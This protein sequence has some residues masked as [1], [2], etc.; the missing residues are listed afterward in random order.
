MTFVYKII[1][2]I[3]YSNGW[4]A[5]GALSMVWQVE[6]IKDGF[7]WNTDYG[8]FLFFATLFV[9]AIHRLVGFTNIEKTVQNR[10]FEVINQFRSHIVIY[11]LIAATGAIYYFLELPFAVVV[12]LLVPIAIAGLYILP[13][14]NG[15]RFR[16]LPYVKLFAIGIVWSWVTVSVSYFLMEGKFDQGL[17]ILSL[18]KMAF[19]IGITIPFDIRDIEVD[20]LYEIKT[21]PRV[22]GVQTSKYLA[23]TSILLSVL[24]AVAAYFANVYS[25]QQLTG[26]SAFYALTAIAIAYVTPDR[27]D[28]YFSGLL[29]GSILLQFVF[30]YFFTIG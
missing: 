30:M 21:L 15:R 25:V 12:L 27:H 16:D 5:L 10:R 24:L 3:L 2:L 6:L 23:L 11:A 19:I 26:M 4:I 7:Q 29:D 22:L 9:Y 28:Y 1:D 20:G 18:E 13:V 17:V 14:F 8:L